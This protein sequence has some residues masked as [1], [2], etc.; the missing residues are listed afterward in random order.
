[1]SKVN[2]VTQ[3]YFL[4]VQYMQCLQY[5]MCKWRGNQKRQSMRK[6]KER[7]EEENNFKGEIGVGKW[8]DRHARNLKSET[9]KV[10]QG[11]R[12]CVHAL[13]YANVFKYLGSHGLTP[14]QGVYSCGLYSQ[15]HRVWSLELDPSVAA[16]IPYLKYNLQCSLNILQAQT[17][18]WLVPWGAVKTITTDNWKKGSLHTDICILLYTGCQCL[19]F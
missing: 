2:R 9:L 18:C 14:R 7:Q 19:I 17:Q 10:Q 8:S 11:Y 1:M 15:G 3:M 13:C 5:F 16:F 4:L 12:V 6:W